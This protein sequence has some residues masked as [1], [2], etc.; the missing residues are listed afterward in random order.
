MRIDAGQL[1]QALINLLTNAAEAT[2]DIAAPRVTVSARLSRRARLRIEVRDNGHG[3]PDT[4]AAHIFMPFFSTR[5]QGRGI[6]LALVRHLAH[7]N[8]GTLRYARPVGAGACF[9]LSF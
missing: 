6:G 9:L 8:G 2:Q 4:L 3:V 5:K 1:E 7:A